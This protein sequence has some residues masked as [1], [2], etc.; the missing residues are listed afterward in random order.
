MNLLLAAL[1]FA[2]DGHADT[3]QFLLDLG[4]DLTQAGE[5]MVDLPK[6][7][8]GGLGGEFFSIWVDPEVYRATPPGAP[9]TSSIPCAYRWNDTRASWP[10][11]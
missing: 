8:Q 10:W 1:V 5:Q 11:R 2:L 7:R 6:A 9:S 3:P 4:T